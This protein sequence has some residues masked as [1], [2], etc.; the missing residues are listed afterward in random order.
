[1]KFQSIENHKPNTNIWTCRDGQE[2]RICDMSC[3][4]L[5]NTIRMLQENLRPLPELTG[6]KWHNK[7]NKPAAWIQ[8]RIRWMQRELIIKIHNID[9]VI[10]LELITEDPEIVD[11]IRKLKGLQ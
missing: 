3:S 10:G 8:K 4:H 7:I 9:P 1:M 5:L 2:I 11:V 6:T